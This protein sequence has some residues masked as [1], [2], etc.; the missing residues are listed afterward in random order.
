M[1]SCE[2]EGRWKRSGRRRDIDSITIFITMSNFTRITCVQWSSPRIHKRGTVF[3]LVI[4][5]VSLPH[6][7]TGPTTGRV[8]RT[9][10]PPSTLVPVELRTNFTPPLIPCKRSHLANH[11]PLVFEALNFRLKPTGGTEAV[12]I[13]RPPLIPLAEPWH[14]KPSVGGVIYAA[15]RTNLEKSCL[16]Q[17][18]KFRDFTTNTH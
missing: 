6:W 13:P 16:Q 3:T 10:K 8:S 4:A 12:T 1:E 15:G 7:S 14:G 9:H 18:Q 5:Q 2:L 17:E 11:T